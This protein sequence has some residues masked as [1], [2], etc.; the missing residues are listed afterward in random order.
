VNIVRDEINIMWSWDLASSLA[1][2]YS[3]VKLLE[4]GCHLG[5]MSF[6]TPFPR[7]TQPQ[8]NLS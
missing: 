8:E 4:S 2:P 5:T 6:V 1:Q 3:S 7:Y